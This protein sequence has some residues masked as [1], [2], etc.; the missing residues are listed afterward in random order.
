MY[1][2]D[3]WVKYLPPGA[4]G[5]HFDGSGDGIYGIYNKLRYIDE[6]GGSVRNA[7]IVIDRDGMRVTK[8]RKSV[9]Y[10]SPPCL[11]KESEVSYYAEL[12]KPFFHI[13]FVA[14]YLGLS[15]FS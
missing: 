8:N 10:I 7:L 14:G 1:R 2:V 6:T 15:S 11:S 12:M 13:R 4:S 9:L 3:N 5:F